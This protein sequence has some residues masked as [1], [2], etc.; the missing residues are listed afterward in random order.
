MADKHEEARLPLAVVGCDFRVASSRWRSR[1]VL[2]REEATELWQSLRRVEAAEGFADLNTCNRTEW[3]VSTEQAGWAVELLRAFMKQRVGLDEAPWFE[4]YAYVGARAAEHMLRVAV[5]LESLVVGERQIAGQLYDALEEARMRGTSSRILNGLGVVS[6]RLVRAAVRRGCLNGTGGGV[7]G[8]AVRYLS[9]HMAGRGP[10][11]VLVVGLGNI[12]RQ[13]AALLESQ[14]T[15]QPVL[16]NR[17][18]PPERAGQVHALSA[19]PALLREVD[20]AIICTGAPTLVLPASELP[21][22][23]PA[24]PLLVVDIGIPEQVAR[25]G[26]PEHVTV[27]GLDELTAFHLGAR[28]AEVTPAC[29]CEREVDFSLREF[30][31]FCAEPV[32]AEILD[33][34]HKRHGHLVRED[35]PAA[36]ADLPDETRA[37]VVDEL[38]GCIRGYTSEVLKTIRSQSER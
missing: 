4:P 14:P 31:S 28:G 37:R 27:A 11:R 9:H 25:E 19:L 20:A 7:H 10:L 34:V 5:G 17:S 2:T 38:R 36:L 26:A 29:E 23:D 35:L 21:T 30:R 13:V 24:R 16:C 15:M 1:L 18:V 3:V 8:L 22:R 32:F 33:T 6:G 12:G